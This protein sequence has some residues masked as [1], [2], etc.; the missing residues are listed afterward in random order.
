MHG[1][2]VQA[3][4]RRMETCFFEGKQTFCKDLGSD[5]SPFTQ[6]AVSACQTGIICSLY[7]IMPLNVNQIKALLQFAA[8][9]V[10]L[11]LMIIAKR[12]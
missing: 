10:I 4:F 2:A 11:V 9:K 12:V 1:S 5:S 3:A 8:A 6:S 7:D